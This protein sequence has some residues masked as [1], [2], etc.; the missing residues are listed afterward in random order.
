MRSRFLVTAATL[1]IT[2]ATLVSTNTSASARWWG[3]G[4][5]GWGGFAAGALV[6]GALASTAWAPAYG[7]YDRGYAYDDDYAYAPSYSYYGYSPGYTTTYSYSYSPRG[8]T[9][10]PGYN[11][12]YGYSP[13]AYGYVEQ[14]G[15]D[16]AYCMQRFRSYD[17]RTGTY[18][19][20]D[21][22]RHPCP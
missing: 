13:D 20:F 3:H 21:G 15:G 22:L 17:R 5:G 14:G 4:W 2:G 16:V 1:A 8:Y 6:G 10:S 11:Y 12:S 7:W 18:L 19:G 9:Y